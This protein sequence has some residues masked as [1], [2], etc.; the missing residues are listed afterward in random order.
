M[1]LS[2]RGPLTCPLST[3]LVLSHQVA[4]KIQLPSQ[5]QDRLLRQAQNKPSEG[6]LRTRAV[7]APLAVRASEARA[8]LQ[9]PQACPPREAAHLQPAI[10]KSEARRALS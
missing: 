10:S 6:W 9:R 3:L 8:A 4:V 2:R 5:A 1:N 7:N